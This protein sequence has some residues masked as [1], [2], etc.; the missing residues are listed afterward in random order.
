MEIIVGT[1]EELLLG[2][3]F[4]K[5]D[6]GYKLQQTFTN[7]SHI[8]CVKCLTCQKNLLV[9]GSTD[10]SIRIFDL[11]KR[12]ELGTLHQHLG[13]V[14]SLA[15]FQKSHL[16][17]T[18][19][20]STLCVWKVS[21]W[22]PV[23]TFKGH[24]GAVNCVS[25]HPS[26]KL[27]LTVSRDRSLRL[28]NLVDGRPAFTSNIKHDA[29]LVVWS[30]DG[31]FY[32]V[33]WNTTINVHSVEDGSI[34]SSIIAASRV[35]SIVFVKDNIV[36]YA[37]GGGAIF[38]HD[39]MEGT[40]L[41]QLSTDTSRIRGLAISP[42]HE[43]PTDSEELW[44]SAASSDGHI[45]VYRVSLG[46]NTVET[47]LL[48]FHNTTFRLTCITVT[49]PDVEPTVEPA[50]P[51]KKKRKAE[52]PVE[53]LPKKVKKETEEEQED[54]EREMSAQTKQPTSEHPDKRK[55][56]KVGT[57]KQ[58]KKMKKKKTEQKS[59]HEDSA[60]VQASTQMKPKKKV[61]FGEVKVREIAS[62]RQL[63]SLQGMNLHGKKQNRP[64]AQ[65]KAS[66]K[67]LQKQ[68]KMQ[69][70]QRRLQRKGKSML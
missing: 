31:N 11:K 27:A 21:G 6:N 41:Y 34:H 14:T 56:E 28:W 45:K 67:A 13:T 20:D 61:Q 68:K 60:P 24:K 19:E 25:V 59:S 69:N 4:V 2:Y 55:K 40:Q 44:L 70:R 37:G 16:F 22:E 48:T 47:E 29:D 35:N 7:H 53:S 46:K 63:P 62:R 18:S 42:S 39:I 17:S 9:S 58:S 26:G 32:V 5:E 49:K 15:F 64:V 10:E 12:R 51:P 8:G 1:Y 57:M 66:K 52:K 3:A 65:G 43:N 36:A 54:A 50:Q 30:P 38:F 33:C 23:R